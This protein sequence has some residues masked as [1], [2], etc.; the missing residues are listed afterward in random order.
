MPVL[1]GRLG[2]IARFRPFFVISPFF[3]DFLDIERYLLIKSQALFKIIRF[4]AKSKKKDLCHYLRFFSM[5]NCHLRGAKAFKRTMKSYGMG[6]KKIRKRPFLPNFSPVFLL[7]KR[8]FFARFFMKLSPFE[9]IATLLKHYDFF[10]T[11]EMVEYKEKILPIY[12]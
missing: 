9:E 2:K 5:H 4:P 11:G 6:C 1:N 10:H 12:L 7:K 8:P 3:C